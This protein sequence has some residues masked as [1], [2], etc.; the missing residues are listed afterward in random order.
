MAIHR[1]VAQLADMNTKPHALILALAVCSCLTGCNKRSSNPTPPE[2]PKIL[3]VHI[4]EDFK[5]AY[6]RTI[7]FGGINW[8]T[9]CSYKIGHYRLPA[10]QYRYDGRYFRL[11]PDGTLLEMVRRS[12]TEMVVDS[13]SW[14][15]LSDRDCILWSIGITNSRM[16]RYSKSEKVY[17]VAEIRQSSEGSTTL[18]GFT[19][20]KDSQFLYTGM[21]R[22]S[23]LQHI[24]LSDIA[25]VTTTDDELRSIISKLNQLKQAFPA[26]KHIA[27]PE[28]TFFISVRLP[29]H[30]GLHIQFT[31]NNP[32]AR[33]ETMI[34]VNPNEKPSTDGH[35][36]D[37]DLGFL[38]LQVINLTKPV[39]SR[40]Q[41]DDLND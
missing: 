22:E 2:G 37:P 18:S 20:G 30:A 25:N 21:T 7:D 3:S 32:Q 39:L 9:K 4:N 27:P 36:M 28:A 29:N 12:K 13:P 8:T 19:E 23:A 26:S 6:E 35:R 40:W 1:L 34:Y 17:R 16:L 24:A 41:E 15:S 31:S 11:P 5:D 38:E 10:I 33:V 14:N